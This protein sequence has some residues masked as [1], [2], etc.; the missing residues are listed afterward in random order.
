MKTGL[1]YCGPL[2][3]S[4]GEGEEMKEKLWENMGAL[5]NE[6]FVC[7]F[8]LPFFFF[9]RSVLYCGFDGEFSIVGKVYCPKMEGRRLLTSTG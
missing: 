6:F 4:S 1:Q 5:F 3:S 2:P 9:M 7:L 8:V